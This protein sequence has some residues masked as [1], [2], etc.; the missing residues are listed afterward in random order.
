[1]EC[2]SVASMAILLSAI[3]ALTV[4]LIAPNLSFHFDVTPKVSIL[5]IG[6]SGL[7]LFPG[8]VKN[9]FSALLKRSPGRWLLF[10][11]A[12]NLLS[13]SIS[14]ALSTDAALS[15]N[16][17]GWR[18][19]GLL[20]QAGVLLFAVLLAGCLIE[21][22][23]GALWFLRITTIT[24]MLTAIYGAM[25]YFG[26][27]PI[28]P[29]AAYNVGEGEWTI[30]RPPG[31]LGHA[32]YF[33]T[34]QLYAV[35]AAVAL[36]TME[37][38]RIGRWIASCGCLLGVCAIV[39]SG[40]R[41][42]ILGL[43]AGGIFLL[44]WKRPRLRM[45][46]VAATLLFVAAASA[47]Y[48]SP[49]GLKLRGRTRWYIEDRSGGARIPVWRD[50]LRMSR[51]HPALG[52]GPETFAVQYPRFQSL[53]VARAY[54]DF[55]QESPHNIFLD[56]L[57]AQGLPGLLILVGFCGVAVVGI[58]K[59]SP[60]SPAIGAGFLAGL[61][62][63][64]FLCFTVPT[65]VFFYAMVAVLASHGTPG[66]PHKLP[67]MIPLAA[68]LTALFLLTYAVRLAVTD[69][70]LAQVKR[71]LDAGVYETAAA[72]YEQSRRWRPAGGSADLYYSRA[73]FQVSQRQTDTIRRFQ[74]WQHAMAAAVRAASAA[75]DR[76]NA[77]VNLA[78]FQ[79]AVNDAAAVEDSLRAASAAAPNWYKPK[80]LLARL[81]ELTGRL[82]EAEEQAMAAVERNGGHD[83][84]VRRTLQEVQARR[85][86]AH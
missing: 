37:Q 56:A 3:A 25:Q 62:A 47:F 59:G 22:R 80:W 40:T 79:S 75:E 76:A 49:A 43:A 13:L 44:A 5:L 12:L 36:R 39:L 48:Y 21:E 1:M 54:P 83:P 29:A 34:F 9:S 63:Q 38:N 19:F 24:G 70:L 66:A 18:Q 84:E 52:F 27:D 82:P 53:E 72:R 73:M 10:L 45:V 17:S 16:G 77:L 65:A 2:A 33:A 50:S 69:A 85:D 55:Y 4:L 86:I 58:R 15:L 78:A 26:W 71:D 41:S 81:Y 14:T 68:A 32:S 67:R 11:A 7:L 30:V 42:A 8:F 20:T 74:A 51:E 60:E 6:I 31:T 35:F 28:L 23:N 64:Q 61:V 46:H 57:V